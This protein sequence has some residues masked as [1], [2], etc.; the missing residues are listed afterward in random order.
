VSRLSSGSQRLSGSEFQVDRP[1]RQSVDDRNC[2]FDS[3]A[4]LTSADWQTADVD[5]QWRPLLACNCPSSMAEQ[6]RHRYMSTASLNRTPVIF[7][8]GSVEPK[9]SRASTKGSAADQQKWPSQARREPQRGPGKHSRGAPKTFLR[10][11]FLNFSFQNGAFWCI[12]VFLSD[13]GAP[14]TSRGPG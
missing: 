8:R 12:F 2:S 13:G 5:D 7:N 11:K 9:V 4:R 6:L 1:Q 14:Q 3:A 10:G